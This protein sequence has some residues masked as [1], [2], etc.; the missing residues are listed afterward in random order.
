MAL[1]LLRRVV[2]SAPRSQRLFVS[3]VVHE[4]ADAVAISFHLQRHQAKHFAYRSGQF[5]TVHVP[6]DDGSTTARCY[7][8]CTAPDS[9]EPL[10][11]AVKRVPDGFASNWLCDN[12][13]PGMDLEVGRPAGRFVP[14]STTVDVAVFAAGSG[15]TPVLSIVPWLLRNGT[16]HIQLVY[17]NRDKDSVMFGERLRELA[18]S[19]ADRLVLTEWLESERGLPTAEGLRELVAWQPV[20]EAFL[21]GPSAFMDIA[22]D[23]LV[24]VGIEA[25]KIRRENFTSTSAARQVPVDVGSQGATAV[26]T[27]RG[28][29]TSIDWKPGTVLLDNLIEQKVNI[30]Y[31]CREGVCG[32]CAGRLTSGE[33]RMLGNEFLEDHEIEAGWRLACQSLPVSDHV[34]ILFE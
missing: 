32:G 25:D 14:T 23:F 28:R 16:G 1:Q 27:H 10:T 33:V 22:N 11:I 20:D 21:C 4:T 7:S 29:T 18:G 34:E 3:E 13:E 17:A 19:H 12:A 2:P 6:C 9:G 24:G 30:P 15:I 26:V 31:V 8:L 5:L